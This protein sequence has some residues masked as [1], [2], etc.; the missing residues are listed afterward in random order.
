MFG[1]IKK[2][3]F[4][5]MM[6]FHCNV[7]SVN[8]LECVSINNQEWKVR[9]EIININSNESLLYP[10]SILVN[11]CSGSC[12]NI[13]DPFAKLCVPDVIKDKY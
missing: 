6:F 11:K 7:V 3:F 8:P 1:F 12:N 4:A 10:Y 13:N 5:T 9:P 2:C